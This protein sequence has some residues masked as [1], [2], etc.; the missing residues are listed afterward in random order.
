[1]R[2]IWTI[3]LVFALLDHEGHVR[4]ARAALM[5]RATITPKPRLAANAS[6]RLFL[7]AKLGSE[8]MH[9]ASSNGWRMVGSGKAS[10]FCSGG[11]RCRCLTSGSIPVVPYHW[12][13][14]EATAG[15]SARSRDDGDLMGMAGA[16][17]D[18]N[19]WAAPALRR[20]RLTIGLV[21]L[22][23]TPALAFDFARYRRGPISTTS[24]RSHGRRPASASMAQNRCG[25]RSSSSPIGETS[26]SRRSRWP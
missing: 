20:L 8:N 25:S 24:W 4:P 6:A 15:G 7:D 18:G 17:F 11:H 3:T 21:A 10:A 22:V 19:K 13:G 9:G 2:W 12:G 23:A 26:P 5:R 16:L 14:R 1:M